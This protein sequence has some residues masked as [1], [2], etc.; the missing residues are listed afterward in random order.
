ME[1]KIE[2]VETC[3]YYECGKSSY[4][5]ID[6]PGLNKFKNNLEFYKTK[7]NSA[8]GRRSYIS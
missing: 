4:Y 6:C 5:L 2:G 7:R 3:D 1:K 8:K